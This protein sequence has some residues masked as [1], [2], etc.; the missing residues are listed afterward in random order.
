MAGEEVHPIVRP[1]VIHP[2]WALLRLRPLK[3]GL[4]FSRVCSGWERW[5]SLGLE[6]ETDPKSLLL[7]RPKGKLKHIDS[8]HVFQVSSWRWTPML[9]QEVAMESLP[10]EWVENWRNCTLLKE[11]CDHECGDV[12]SGRAPK[13]PESE[14]GELGPSCFDHFT[15]SKG[16]KS[17]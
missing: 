12:S 13:R 3:G 11:I 8:V 16:K 6:E 5:G 4:H 15:P 2:T 7:E 1:R 14:R 9:G 17:S 10:W